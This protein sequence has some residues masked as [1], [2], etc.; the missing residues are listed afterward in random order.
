[1]GIEAANG[2]IIAFTD[3]DCIPPEK[4][5]LGIVRTFEKYDVISVGGIDFPHPSVSNRLA[6]EVDIERKRRNQIPDTNGVVLVR[7]QS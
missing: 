2:D 3:D 7:L 4:W 5:L 1:L 6:A